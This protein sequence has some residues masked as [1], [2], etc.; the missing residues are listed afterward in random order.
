VRVLIVG[1]GPAAAGAAIALTKTEGVTVTVLD[2]GGRLEDENE[3]ARLRMSQSGPA[4]WT[5]VDLRTISQTAVAT[6]QQGLPEKR[7]YGSDFPF[8]D[9]GQLDGVSGDGGMNSHVI[10]GAYGG[11]SNTW[12]AQT[13]AFSAATFDDWPFPRSELEQDYRAILDAIPYSAEE[14]DL[15]EYFP[16]WGQ[17]DALP[18]LSEGSTRVL[19]AYRRKVT[20]LR[21]QGILIG[22]ARLAMSGHECISC[23]LCMTGCPYS[24]VYSASQ[25][26]DDLVS[27]GRIEYV[28]NHVALRVGEKDRQPFVQARSLSSGA[29]ETFSADKIFVACGA[30]GTTRLV[31]Q[32]LEA[33]SRRVHL[34]EAS[35]FLVPFLSPKGAKHL[36]QEGSFTLNQFNMLLPFDEVGHD[37]VQIHGYPYNEAMDEALPGPLQLPSLRGVKSAL[38][39]RITIGLGYLPSWWSAG[40]DVS[41][42][43]PDADGQLAAM[44]LAPSSASHELANTKLR[45]VVKRLVVAGPHLGIFPVVP[46]IKLA[47]P[48]KS[49]HFGG[50]FPHASAPKDGLESDILG[51]VQPWHNIHLV[52]ASVFP[53]VPATTFTLSI[54]ANAHRIARR[55]L[56][57]P[58]G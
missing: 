24:Y 53:T 45:S 2:V 11:F 39:K 32:S 58:H 48:T 44:A 22:K 12:G 28:G 31:T 30:L 27:R 7:V 29:L 13:M 43:R 10:S 20:T 35:Q 37:L 50:S 8:H 56:E 40:F 14:D 19:E 18:S 49:Y 47:A 51:R 33:W 46:Q 16:I 26:F 9:F 1:A 36:T 55:A 57:G 21:R 34:I 38:L 25:T 5:A 41:F 17:A 6:K 52:D 4:S 23:G 15:A 54:M 42:T 3:R